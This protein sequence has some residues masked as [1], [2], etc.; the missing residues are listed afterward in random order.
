MNRLFTR[1]ALLAGL[2]MNLGC[3]VERTS[4]EPEGRLEVIA[5]LIANSL[6]IL[7][8]DWA[9]EGPGDIAGERLSVTELG[10]VPA[11]RITNGEDSFAIVRRIQA[12][13]LA[14]PY[15]NWAWNMGTYGGGLHPVRLVV[16]FH[17]GNPEEG[18]WGSQ[19]FAWLG[20]SLPPHDRSLAIVWGDSALMRGALA[21]PD[22]ERP[23][24]PLYTARGGRE[25][26]GQWWLEDAD[27]SALYARAWPGDEME[28]VQVVFIGIAATAGNPQAAAH[29]SEVVLSR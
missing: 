19:P 24:V 28:R 2:A 23:A 7:P 4:V 14:T 11:L 20:T 25:N 15:L 8:A 22:G 6:R 5:P 1:L 3:A 26:T 17:G 10:G 21:L 16:G 12:M 29:I 18:S 13:L 27:L 9:V